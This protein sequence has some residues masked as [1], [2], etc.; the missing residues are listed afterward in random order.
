MQQAT[1]EAASYQ[2]ERPHLNVETGLAKHA[3][4]GQFVKPGFIDT[5]YN[6]HENLD[7][8]TLSYKQPERDRETDPLLVTVGEGRLQALAVNA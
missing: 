2:P 6:K 8:L 1:K 3:I 7:P 5:R 4:R